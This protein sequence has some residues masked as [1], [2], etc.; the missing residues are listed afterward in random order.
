MA[1]VADRLKSLNGWQR[2]WLVATILWLTAT[3]VTAF[4]Q[5]PSRS[6][7]AARNTMLDYSTLV[8]KE[9]EC[10]RFETH[11]APYNKCWE[12]VPAATIESQIDSDL[13]QSDMT[14]IG[15]AV[16]LGF[17]PSVILYGLGRTTFWI[18]AGFKQSR[19]AVESGE[20]IQNPE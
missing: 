17:V 19:K 8:G 11:S 9:N 13:L 4:I 2:I 18:A 5:M 1:N 7:V 3:G 12:N 15:C 20:H 14:V 6:Q 10:N 16:F